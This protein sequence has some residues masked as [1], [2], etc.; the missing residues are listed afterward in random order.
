MNN[1][2]RNNA[3]ATMMMHMMMCCRQSYC[4]RLQSG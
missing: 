4:Q 2:L 1:I 3:M